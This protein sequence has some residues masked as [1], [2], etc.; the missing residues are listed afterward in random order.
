MMVDRTEGTGARRASEADST[1]SDRG[2]DQRLRRDSASGGSRAP[3][4]ARKPETPSTDRPMIDPAN[5]RERQ[6]EQFGGLKPGAAFFGWLVAV[7]VGVLLTAL[8]SAAG[9]AIGLSRTAPGQVDPGQAQTI[10]IV[11][12]VVLLVI[13]FLAYFA[14]GYVAGRLARFDGARQGLGVW[15]IALAVAIV[16]AAAG[17]LL[18]AQYNVLDQLQVVPRIPADVGTLTT[19]GLIALLAVVVV[20]LIAAILGGKAGE[21]FHKKVDRAGFGV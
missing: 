2:A 15:L 3:E 20:T 19:A 6:H 14:G 21:R 13:L 12:G 17:A 1:Q 18:G 16:I 5:A 8:L 11:S 7:G 9:G 10:G 4:R